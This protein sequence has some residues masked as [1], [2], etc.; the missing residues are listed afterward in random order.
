MK[1]H[2]GTNRSHSKQSKKT[3]RHVPLAGTQAKT[4]DVHDAL[5]KDE[6]SAFSAQVCEAM[7]RTDGSPLAIAQTLHEPTSVVIAALIHLE[8]T[9]RV[10]AKDVGAQRS[11]AK[12]RG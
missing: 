8:Q 10:T 2:P 5:F 6:M 7:E 9:G 12:A 4:I 11:W 1:K 3:V